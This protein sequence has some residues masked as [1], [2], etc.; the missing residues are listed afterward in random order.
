MTKRVPAKSKTLEAATAVLETGMA[1][2]VAQIVRERAAMPPGHP[3]R[4]PRHGVRHA[5]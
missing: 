1:K 3:P 2:I 4:R 5:A